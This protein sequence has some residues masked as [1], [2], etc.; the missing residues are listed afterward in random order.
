MKNY[1]S[2]YVCNILSKNECNNKEVLS[3]NYRLAACVH[4]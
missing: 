4:Q 3:F 2:G 1:S